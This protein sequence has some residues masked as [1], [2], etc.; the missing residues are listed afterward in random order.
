[1]FSGSFLKNGNQKSSS[2]VREKPS[3]KCERGIQVI[4]QN[5]KRTDR[6]IDSFTNH[7]ASHVLKNYEVFHT[8]LTLRNHYR[9]QTQ[10]LIE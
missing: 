10:F 5:V 8:Y 6:Q 3:M 2:G 4:Y 1:M 7:Q 9:T